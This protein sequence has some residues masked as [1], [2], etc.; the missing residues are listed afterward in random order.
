MINGFT[1]RV[2]LDFAVSP[3]RSWRLGG[4]SVLYCGFLG[5]LRFRFYQLHER[6]RD[7]GLLFGGL[8]TE[9]V[10]DA[11]QLGRVV[12]QLDDGDD[13]FNGLAIGG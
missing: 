1:K 12:V 9:V 4:K 2:K 11:D 8:L 3:L 5:S 7:N 10:L 6:Q 13:F